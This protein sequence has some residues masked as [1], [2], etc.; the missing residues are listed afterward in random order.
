MTTLQ[1]AAVVHID[2]SKYCVF[3]YS[4]FLSPSPGTA[5]PQP[6]H[7]PSLGADKFRTHQHLNTK[8]CPCPVKGAL[9][10]TAVVQG[11]I[12][13]ALSARARVM[14]E[15]EARTSLGAAA[16]AGTAAAGTSSF[17]AAASN[18]TTGDRQSSLHEAFNRVSQD[19]HFKS[20]GVRHVPMVPTVKE[21]FTRAFVIMMLA[22]LMPTN[23]VA[24]PWVS[25]ALQVAGATAITRAKV[26]QLIQLLYTEFKDKIRNK[27]QGMWYTVGFDALSKYDQR[28]HGVTLYIT[29]PSTMTVDVHLLAVNWSNVSAL[30]SPALKKIL[31]T[32]LAKFDLDPKRMLAVVTDNASDM[33]KMRLLCAEDH[34]SASLACIPHFLAVVVADALMFKKNKYVAVVMFHCRRVVGFFRSTPTAATALEAEIKAMI[35]TD[36]AFSRSVG[37]RVLRVLGSAM[38][39]WT[40]R[41]LSLRRLL[42]LLPAIESLF[43]KMGRKAV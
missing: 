11:M 36:E 24:N 2:G 8:R 12:Q 35:A 43:K 40:T 15:L 33:T 3:C 41:I 14:T 31:E 34:K 9:T 17:S 25:N 13:E 29:N 5:P 22:T 39:R 32:V 6:Q 38:T 37:G 1:Q 23:I 20:L 19:E 26:G 18:S 16:A 30:T 28:Y 42:L 7:K 10:D 4:A 27:F 21:Y